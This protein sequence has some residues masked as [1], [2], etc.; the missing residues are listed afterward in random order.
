MHIKPRV[1]L[2]QAEFDA[3]P[4]SADGKPVTLTPEGEAFK[5]F[6]RGLKK[7]SAVV[8]SYGAESRSAP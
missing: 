6:T 8:F 2:D 1:W 4:G 5:A 7:G 3:V